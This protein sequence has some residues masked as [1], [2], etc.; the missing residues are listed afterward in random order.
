MFP[1]FAAFFRSQTGLSFVAYINKVKIEHA[2]RLLIETDLKSEAVGFDCGFDSPS[3]F[4]KCFK[5]HYGVSP[6]RYRGAGLVAKTA[7]AEVPLSEEL[8][9]L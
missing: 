5:K 1:N 2:A 7:E 3:H 4:Y 8:L 9:L 6:A